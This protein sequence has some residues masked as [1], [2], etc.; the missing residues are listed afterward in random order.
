MPTESPLM[1]VVDDQLGVRR[2]IQE[3]FKEVGFRVATAAHGQEAVAIA[4]AEVPALVLLDMKMP[5]MDGL[6]TLRA[7]KSLYPDLIVL[8]MTAVGDGERV[9][10]ALSSGAVHCVSKPFDVFELRQLVQDVLAEGEKA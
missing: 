3:V 7:L 8:M 10:E 1:L 5:V 9:N 4:A 6:E 2:L